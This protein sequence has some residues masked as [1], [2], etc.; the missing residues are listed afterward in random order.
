MTTTHDTPVILELVNSGDEANL[1]RAAEL[2]AQFG[3]PGPAFDD[4]VAHTLVH[5]AFGLERSGRLDEAVALYRRVVDSDIVFA[6]T[7]AH[8]SLRLGLTLLQRGD[9]ADAAH[10]LHLASTTA[11]TPFI[12]RLAGYHGGNVLNEL[13]EPQRALEMYERM[14]AVE[15][16][17]PEEPSKLAADYLVSAMRLTLGHSV[18][19]LP[20]AAENPDALEGSGAFHLAAVL[21]QAD[22][23][24]QA[25]GFYQVVLR[26]PA[27][28][29]SMTQF[30]RERE[31]LL[32]QQLAVRKAPFGAAVPVPAV[33]AEIFRLLQRKRDEDDILEANRLCDLLPQHPTEYVDSVVH[34]LMGVGLELER[35]ARPNTASRLYRRVIAIPDAEEQNRRNAYFRLGFLHVIDNKLD[36]AAPLLHAAIEGT[37]NKV[38]IRQAVEYLVHIHALRA[39]W[40]EGLQVVAAGAA[41]SEDDPQESL[42]WTLRGV[43]FRAHLNEIEEYDEAAENILPEDLPQSPR[44]AQAWFDAGHALEVSGYLSQARV[45]YEELL[46]STVLPPG[47]STRLRFRLGVV[48]DRLMMFREAQA[49][50]HAAVISEDPDPE[51]QTEAR[52][53]LANLR[54][55][56]DEFD[57]V[58]GDFEDLRRTGGSARVRA[59]S[60]LR[61]ATCLL[62]LGKSA[63]SKRELETSRT[64][65]L[66]GT[67]F[68]VKADLMLAEMAENAADRTAAVDAYERVIHNPLSEPLTKA[69]ALARVAALRKGRR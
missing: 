25:V 66:H 13:G 68:E 4:P 2:V 36:E 49:M 62:R 21:E 12:I 20:P 19:S 24:E 42:F 23:I 5:V 14:S 37:D 55:L 8:A 7:R 63:E 9:R 31:A 11:I 3:P 56:M 67:E 54:F 51:S 28:P 17:C 57:A 58:I 26:T 69:A 16:S 48:L 38:I 64:E 60:Q 32:S 34:A 6:D 52:L 22:R 65:L 61:Y 43:H 27:I 39:E 30:A 47:L 53:R 29:E 18:D 15:P 45:F 1:S 59:E 35:I 33:C 46:D 10:A 41:V 50:L 44:V 40:T